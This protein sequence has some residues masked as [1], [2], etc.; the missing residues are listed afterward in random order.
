MKYNLEEGAVS[1]N[2]SADLS[3]SI[4]APEHDI[5][6]KAKV[7]WYSTTHLCLMS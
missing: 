7:S 2:Q 4:P 3:N 5:P 1:V 6:I